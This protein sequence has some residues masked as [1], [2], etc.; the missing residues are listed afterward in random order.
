ML[1]DEGVDVNAKDENGN[2]L[3]TVAA[4]NGLKRIT[5]LLLRR[6]AGMNEVVRQCKQR[7]CVF[8]FRV[9]SSSCAHHNQSVRACLQNLRGNTALH[10]AYAYKFTS[11]AEYLISKGADDSITNHEGLTCYEGLDAD[12]VDAI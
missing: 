8:V 12:T 5:K 11:L 10:Y 2:S 1:L 4:Q 6:G 3:L 7:V 9:P